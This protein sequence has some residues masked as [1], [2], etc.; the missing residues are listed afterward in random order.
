MLGECAS[1]VEERLRFG[2]AEP[3]T[4]TEVQ[5]ADARGE[6]EGFRVGV[7]RIGTR[8]VPDGPPVA[9]CRG[10]VVVCGPVGGATMPAR[11][12]EPFAGLLP[13]MRDER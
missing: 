13:V 5:D 8:D 9:E 7:R 2:F 3:V 6:R 11:A 4:G 10:R 12:L 1:F